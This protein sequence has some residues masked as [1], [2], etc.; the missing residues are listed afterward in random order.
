[1][2]GTQGKRTGGNDEKNLPLIT[3]LAIVTGTTFKKIYLY[4]QYLSGKVLKSCGSHKMYLHLKTEKP[5]LGEDFLNLASTLWFTPGR[6]G[7]DLYSSF[8]ISLYFI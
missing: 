6:V 3:T 2:K 1:L 4:G 7:M 8:C 5:M